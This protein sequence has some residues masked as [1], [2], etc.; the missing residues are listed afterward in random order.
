MKEAKEI[1]PTTTMGKVKEG[2]W[3]VDVREKEEVNELSFDVPNLIHIPLT[4]FETRFE[5][6]PK[7]SEIILACK[8]GSRSLRATYFLMNHGWN[9]VFNM[10]HGIIRWAQ[11]D[12][13]TKGNK[14]SVLE[15]RNEG[16]CCG[17]NSE[18]TSCC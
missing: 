11:K 9:N 3:V 5:E 14:N 13:P 4:E 18:S 12:F 15:N 17:S 6:I 7:E 16:S 1:C 8:S 2:A 10:Q